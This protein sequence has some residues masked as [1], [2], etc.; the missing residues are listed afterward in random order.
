MNC[1]TIWQVL[2]QKNSTNVAWKAH[3]L[4]DRPS[5]KVITDPETIKKLLNE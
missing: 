4:E 1:S 2:Q 5:G 3:Q